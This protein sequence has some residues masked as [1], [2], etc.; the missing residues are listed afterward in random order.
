M[1]ILHIAHVE[2][3]TEA[4]ETGSYRV[5]TR[6]ATLDDV[7]FI[8]ASSDRGQAE[9]VARFIYFDD[10]EPLCVLVIDEAKIEASG[11]ALE[12]EDGGAGELFP[13]IYGPIDPGWVTEVLPASFDED[14]AFRF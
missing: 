11:T 10:E 7:D 1:S 14:G 3:W 13:H 4:L 9:R 12:Y 8:H 2:D 6:G 5:S